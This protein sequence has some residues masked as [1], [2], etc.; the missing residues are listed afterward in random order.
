M[1]FKI[2]A[3]PFVAGAW[4]SLLV[5]GD[6]GTVIGITFTML[7]LCITKQVDLY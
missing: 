7:A 5:G 4:L 1:K 2:T 6:L 3:I